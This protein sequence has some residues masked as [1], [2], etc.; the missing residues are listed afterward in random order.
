MSSKYLTSLSD[1]ELRYR[2]LGLGLT[3]PI[4]PSDDPWFVRSAW[5]DWWQE[6]AGSFSAEQRDGIWQALD[7]LQLYEVVALEMNERV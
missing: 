5:I 4:V 3:P 6:T 1:G 2:I 7:R